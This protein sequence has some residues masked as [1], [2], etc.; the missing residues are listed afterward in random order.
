VDQAP[1]PHL[2]ACQPDWDDQTW[3][4]EQ[5]S[6]VDEPWEQADGRDFLV[7]APLWRPADS[8][9]TLTGSV[10]LTGDPKHWDVQ[11]GHTAKVQ[12]RL[13]GHPDYAG[14][15]QGDWRAPY[16]RFAGRPVLG[17]NML[18]D[19]GVYLGRR[20]REALIVDSHQPAS[21]VEKAVR[22]WLNQLPSDL[23]SQLFGESERLLA[24][25][26]PY[27]PEVVSA[28]Q[29]RGQLQPDKLVDLGVFIQAG[30]GVCRHQVLLLGVALE[31]AI[32]SGRL[33]G[34]VSL[35]RRHVP[36][37]F[38]HAWVQYRSPEGRI[39]VLDAAHERF[40]WYDQMGLGGHTLYAPRQPKTPPGSLPTA[41]V[42]S[43]SQT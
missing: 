23:A 21:L 22:V 8:G 41:P 16:G 31:R 26:L 17:A 43:Q 9:T 10:Q 18:L 42:P 12:E 32:V 14:P 40:G 35:E 2:S 39:A 24:A 6:R 5:L 11:A 29:E 3:S 20:A 28:M 4:V 33:Y 37:W 1:K 30:G 34:R 27:R 38:S 36:G 13:A 7:P 19:G 15:R 25:F